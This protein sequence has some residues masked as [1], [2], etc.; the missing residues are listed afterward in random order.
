MIKKVENETTSPMILIVLDGWGIGDPNRGNAISLS[1]TPVF[2]SL[3]KKYPNTTLYAHGK[4]V[5][6]PDGQVGNS[7]AGHMNIGA[8]RLVEQESVI[9]SKSIDNGTFVKNSAFLG[10]IR[11]A[12]KMNSKIHLMGML[13]NGQSPHSDPGHLIA[14]IEML[15]NN[16]VK[17]AYL[18]L[19]TD[20][21]DSPKYA[22]L[23]LIQDL[24]KNHLGNFKIATIVG[25]FYAMDRKKKWSRTEKTFNTLTINKG[26]MAST[27]IGAITEAY[28]RGESD[29][30]IE[31]CI[32]TNDEK[33]NTRIEDGDSVIFF[34]LRSDRSRQLTKAFMQHG[35]DVKNPGA[36]LRGKK[37]EHLYFV[38][39]TDFG[40]DLSEVLTAYPGI[41]ITN[42]LPMA[43]A[44]FKQLYL[45]ETEKYAHVT[46]FFNG[47]YSG[48]VAGE[49]QV[50][51]PSPDVKSYDETPS[52]SSS[53]LTNVVLENIKNNKAK[54]DFTFVNFAAPDM[55][56]H[57]GN[58]T[59]GIK[60]CESVDVCL[61]RIV[62]AYLN[63]NG[64]VLVTAD[65][66]N[67]EEM[68]NLETE[69]VYT[70][71]TTNKV[72]FILINKNN[73]KNITLRK[74]GSLCDIAPTI[75]KLLD[76]E[77]SKEMSGKSLI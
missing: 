19:Y 27:A 44:N 24:E 47:G 68:I 46:Y 64:T 56:G 30:Y 77:K 65:H 37:L 49:D 34:N 22:S 18:H 3:I 17:D 10:A 72:P 66:G 12:R 2:N 15:K 59:A 71:H 42:T 48:T 70:E 38:A 73:N 51:V 31:P 40:P 8:G 52:M 69:E 23:K 53:E 62:E 13:S 4:Y 28:N 1:K 7:E 20:G 76:I 35:F 6:L 25:R 55:I 63:I 60:C 43:L 29:E 26:K 16:N 21:R 14:L 75:L 11:H 57:T 67:I 41:D 5:G 50:M 54:Y 61:G 58:I 45:A 36:F 33:T 39:M 74:N 32:I 9:I